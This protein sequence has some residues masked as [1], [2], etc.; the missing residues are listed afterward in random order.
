MHDQALHRALHVDHLE[1]DA[2]ADD[3]A[4]VRVLPARLGVERGLFQDNLDHIAFFGRLGEHPVHDN[5]ADL[6]LGAELGVASEGSRAERRRS[7]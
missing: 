4:G 6:R 5:A 2:V 7:R 1:L 3:P